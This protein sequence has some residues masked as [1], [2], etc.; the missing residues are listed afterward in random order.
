MVKE[1]YPTIKVSPTTKAQLNGVKLLKE[2]SYDS[3][4]IRLL[5]VLENEKN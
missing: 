3:I 2:E 4:I 5:E 1:Q